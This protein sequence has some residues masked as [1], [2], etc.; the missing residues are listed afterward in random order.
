MSECSAVTERMPLLLTESLDATGREQTHQHIEGCDLCGA[1]WSAY[2]ETWL[3][4]GDL[5]EVEVPARVKQNFLNAAGLGETPVANVVPFR[6]RPVVKWVAQA[7]A[8]AVLVGGA[9]FAGD[10]NAERVQPTGA[11]VSNP[12]P[13]TRVA[14]PMSLAETVENR[15][16]FA[17]GEVRRKN[18]TI[19]VIGFGTTLT[20]VM[21][22]CAGEGHY[23]E[24]ADA[25]EL[26][27]SFAAIA[28]SLSDLRV[29]R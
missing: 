1:Q 29:S 26:N 10:R 13:F 17:C 21:K 22:D 23:F 4:L 5:P 19:W 28:D 16:A 11:I 20:D 15:F 24:A 8:V 7:A 6:K 27:A 18:V 9:Y 3:M 25:A 12:S 2:K 14:L